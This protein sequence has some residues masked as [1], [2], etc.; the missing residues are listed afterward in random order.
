M[1]SSK[2]IIFK[3]TFTC[4]KSVIQTVEKGMKYVQN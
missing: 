1:I 4:S 3:L 2:E